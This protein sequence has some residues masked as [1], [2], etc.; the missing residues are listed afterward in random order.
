MNLTTTKDGPD[1]RTLAKSLPLARNR[2][3]FGAK[4]WAGAE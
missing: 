1:F 4:F 3:R 2:Q